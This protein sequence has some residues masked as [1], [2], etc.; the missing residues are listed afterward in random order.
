[1]D[2]RNRLWFCF[3]LGGPNNGVKII[4]S[5]IYQHLS[6]RNNYSLVLVDTAQARD[7]RNFG[8]F[9][10]NKIWLSVR[11][12]WQ[13]RKIQQHDRVYLN[14][15]P[16]GFA[17]YRDMAL[18]F[19][20]LARGGKVTLHVHANGLEKKI[21][22]WNRKLLQKTKIIVINTQQLQALESQGLR[23]ILIPNALPDYFHGAAYNELPEDPCTNR[24]LRLL[25][26]SNLSEEK[27][28]RRL[29]EAVEG[30]ASSKLTVEVRI[31]GGILDDL[32]GKIVDDLVARYAFVTY[33]GPVHNTDKKFELYRKS[34]FVLFLSDE[35]Y[36]VSPL[37]YIESIMSGVPVITTAQVV[38]NT[39]EADGCAFIIDD[40]GS[41]IGPLL[42]NLSAAPEKI[43]MVKSNCRETYLAEYSFEDF[44]G[45]IIKTL[46]ND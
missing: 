5:Y 23:V 18:I 38:A 39:L 21:K 41:E 26:F 25:F 3:P 20:S 34:D 12:L 44:M 7:Y 16:K 37:V 17:H 31:C 42:T 35:Y 27:G 45:K 4:S 32:A 9:N 30:I 8:K 1:M 28:V 43:S 36:E 2:K 6:E 11:L 33:E 46:E 24:A 22:G 29:R 15:T 19:F 10:W 13:V 40:A 14:F